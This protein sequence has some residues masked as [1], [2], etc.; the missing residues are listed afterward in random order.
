M[1]FR[2]LP[3]LLIVSVLAIPSLADNQKSSAPEMSHATRLDLIKAFT[4]ELV[5]VRTTFPMGTKGLKLKNGELSPRGA[6][7]EHELALAGPAVKA[8]DQVM[9]TNILIKNDTIRFVINGGPIKKK[10]WYQHI[11]VGVGGSGGGTGG[12]LGADDPRANPRGTFVDLIFD[13]YIPE[14]DPKQLKTLLRPVFDFD[15]KSGVEA[16]LE[17]V[18]PKVKEAIQNH[19]VL[20]G[21]N[22]EMV[23]YSKGRPPRKTR[24]KGEDGLEYEEW[25]YG[26]PPKDVDFVRFVGDEVVR[27]ETMKVDGQKIVRTEKEVDLSAEP[28]LAKGLDTPA[29]HP[30]GAPTLRRPGETADPDPRL[31]PDARPHGPAQTSPSP[32]PGAPPFRA[33]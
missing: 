16:Y 28:S 24:E 23:T 22:R 13:R 11:S 6:D 30:A 7:L 10:K 8:G 27:V 1:K 26:D 4:A 33:T 12:P 31:D 2:C 32:D 14:L 25:I 20:V 15:S 18:P 17:T 19:N 3:V 5:Y 21:M 29:V 9:I